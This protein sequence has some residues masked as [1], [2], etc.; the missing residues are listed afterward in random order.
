MRARRWD[1]LE[2]PLNEGQVIRVAGCVARRTV[3]LAAL[4]AGGGG[5]TPGWDTVRVPQR[6][7]V[8]WR[9]AQGRT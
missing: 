3:L 4:M 6:C 5:G 9:D 1:G 2:D 8:W 7:E